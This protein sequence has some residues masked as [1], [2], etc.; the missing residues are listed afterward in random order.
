MTNT[1]NSC[2][3]F[4]FLTECLPFA[5]YYSRCHDVTLNKTDENPFFMKLSFWWVKT[6]NR[7]A[8][9]IY[10]C[11]VTGFGTKAL[12]EFGGANDCSIS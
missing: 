4:F 6:D 5:R 11:M 8:L 7:Q 3:F 9:K 1:F 10:T 12:L 2:H